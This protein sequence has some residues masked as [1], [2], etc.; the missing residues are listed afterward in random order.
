MDS[1]IKYREVQQFAQQFNFLG[2]LG[3]GG[4]GVVTK[5]IHHET[6]HTVAVKMSDRK[7]GDLSHEYN[8]YELIR[9][10]DRSLF[11]IKPIA[12]VFGFGEAGPFAWLS[13]ELLGPSV[14][15]LFEQA[16][17]DFSHETISLLAIDMVDCI[18]FFTN[19]E[20]FT[21]I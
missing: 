14:N 15:Q 16:G 6:G 9:Y 10:N 2:E 7:R 13:L 18:T 3:R 5:A 21:V 20:L 8:I 12:S 17:N 1:F 11:K 4:F 19:V